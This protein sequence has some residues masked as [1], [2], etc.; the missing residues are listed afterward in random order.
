MQVDFRY[1]YMPH[2]LIL[3]R[4]YL[5]AIDK[6]KISKLFPT[7]ETCKM[8]VAS[9]LIYLDNDALCL[10]F[11]GIPKTSDFVKI[12]PSFNN[13]DMSKWVESINKSSYLVNSNWDRL[14]Q[15]RL[16]NGS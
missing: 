1:I 9:W 5:A 3:V 15:N 12:N 6:S 8:F 4:L 7:G 13:F 10:P 14:G 16:N 11:F 2:Y